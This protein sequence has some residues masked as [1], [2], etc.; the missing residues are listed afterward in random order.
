VLADTLTGW[1]RT[2]PLDPLESEVVL[3]Q[4]NG[5][6]EWIKIELARQ[7]GVCAAT[8][9]ELPSRF[10]WRT[11]RQVLGTQNV[12]PDSPLDKLPMTW[13]L[14]ALLPGCL[15]DTVFKPVA[16][17]LRGDEPDRLLQL[18]D[19]LLQNSCRYTNSGGEVHVRAHEDGHHVLIEWFDSLPG[20]SDQ[21]LAHLFD[22]LYR[23]EMSR[24]RAKGGSGLGLAICQ[25][26]V[27]AHDGS[28]AASHSPLGG[29]KLTIAFPRHQ[30]HQD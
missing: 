16:G 13:R 20:V 7:A 9:V 21:D 26:I 30:H 25:N 24:N 6:A 10:L 14:M 12:P 15:G 3:V 23:V 17:F 11:Y 8:R 19:N 2:H 28:I 27:N 1:L 29:L 22:R 18:F 4:S 5:M